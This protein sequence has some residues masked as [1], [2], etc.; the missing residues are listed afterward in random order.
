VNTSHPAVDTPPTARVLQ[1]LRDVRHSRRRKG[2][3]MSFES[4]GTD[5]LARVAGGL[6]EAASLRQI[7]QHE[8]GGS[9]HAKNPHSTAFGLGQLI[10]AN[11]VH[12]LGRANANTTD[13]NL[14]LRAMQ[15]YI[16]DRYGNAQRAWGFWQKHHWY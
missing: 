4:I 1:N 9:T 6:S 12:Y 13:Y 11:R 7:I 2:I 3:A 10:Y 5:E 14:Q 15:S 16:H 8:S